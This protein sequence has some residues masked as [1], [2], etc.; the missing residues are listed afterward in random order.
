LKKYVTLLLVLF[1]FTCSSAQ[2]SAQTQFSEKALQ[3][4]VLSLS[5]DSISIADIF[6]DG[7]GAVR[8]I[9]IWATWC[10][11]CIT[12]FPQYKKLYEDFKDK[13]VEFIFFSLDKDVEKWRAGISRYDLPGEHFFLK[14]G[15]EG[16]FCSSID[17]DWIP[18]YMIV[19]QQGKISVFKSIKSDDPVLRA[20][21]ERLLVSGG[22]AN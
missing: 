11:D 19:D 3:E 1:W 5:G 10:R 21:I 16:A 8:V 22:T 17:L 14:E 9:D 18:R 7:A 15:W 4:Q 13:D 20:T 2:D 6:H 12:A